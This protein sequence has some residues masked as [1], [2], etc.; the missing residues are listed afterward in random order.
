MNVADEDIARFLRLFSF[1]DLQEID[2]IQTEHNQKPELRMGQQKLA[3]LVTQ[4]IFGT[5]AAE[6]AKQ[7]SEFMFADNKITKLMACDDVSLSAIAEEIN[8]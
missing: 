5:Q 2:R 7:I 3:Y 6:T 4:I 1:L 8:G